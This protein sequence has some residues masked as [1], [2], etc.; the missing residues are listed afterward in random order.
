[1]LIAINGVKLYAHYYTWSKLYAQ[2]YTRS[3]AIC[4]LLYVELSFM[5]NAIHGVKLYPHCYTSS[6]ALCS[7][8]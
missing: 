1:M 7:L 5:L 8:L 4:S 2:C 3:E 6:E